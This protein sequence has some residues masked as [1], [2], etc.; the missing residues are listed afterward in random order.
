MKQVFR[1][2]SHLTFYLCKKIIEVKG[3]DYD[4]CILFLV[5]DYK[6]PQQ[7]ESAFKHQIHTSFNVDKNKG[8][9]FAGAN[10][11]KTYHNISDFDK[12]VDAY[13]QGEDFYWYA[14]VC[15][16]DTCSLMVTKSNCKGYYVIEDGLGSYLKQNPQ[17]FVGLNYWIYKLILLPF[18]YRIFAVKNNFIYTE[19][20]KFK[21]CI[22]SSQK[23]FPLHQQYLE[24]VG[25]PFEKT[26]LPQT[27]DAIISIDPLFLYMDDSV[28]EKVYEDLSQYVNS[29]GYKSLHYKFHPYFNSAANASIKATYKQLILKLFGE[30]AIELSSNV[31]LENVFN[32]YKCDFYTNR[33]SVALYAYEMGATCYSYSPIIEKYKSD[34]KELAIVDEICIPVKL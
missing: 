20:P 4:D 32:T 24:V 31:V 3:F 11:I 14:Q 6:I 29:K 26:E 8:R 13:L 16:D 27:P 15:N 23:C 10:F 1:I 9:I 25:I 17:T 21:G 28:V 2:S 22:T 7:Y 12:L 34:Y 19:H 30:S 5:R 33:S 18:F